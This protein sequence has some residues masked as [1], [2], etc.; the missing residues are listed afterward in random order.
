MSKYDKTFDEKEFALYN[1]NAT[2]RRIED[3]FSKYRMFK[4]TIKAFY[5]RVSSNSRYFE[6]KVCESN[7]RFDQTSRNLEEI[8]NLKNFIDYCDLIIN[9]HIDELNYYEKWIFDEVIIG[10]K[11][12]S[13]IENDYK[14]D[15]GHMFLNKA[16]KSCILKVSLWFDVYVLNDTLFEELKKI[17]DYDM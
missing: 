5:G 8:I 16:K 2:Y 6:E 15:R 12:L 14:C 9:A 17:K 11:T 10:G 13:S 7:H 1:Y 4:E 3:L